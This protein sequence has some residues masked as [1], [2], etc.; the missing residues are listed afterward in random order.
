MCTF[1]RDTYTLLE[2][3][4]RNLPHT[5]LPCCQNYPTSKAQFRFVCVCVCVCV[6]V[7]G[8]GLYRRSDGIV[9][10]LKD[11]RIILF[12]HGPGVINWRQNFL[13][14]WGSYQQFRVYIVGEM[15]S[16][17]VLNSHGCNTVPNA[18]VTM[19]DKVMTQRTVA[20]VCII[21]KSVSIF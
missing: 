14:T 3:G 9:E 21:W 15:M 6:C 2:A 20:G 13:C 8:G 1:Y 10:A 11:H 19:K 5:F 17:T 12:F 7:G 16:Y 18:H 4:F